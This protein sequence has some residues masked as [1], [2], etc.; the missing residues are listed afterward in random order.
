MDCQFWLDCILPMVY[1]NFVIISP[2][3]LFS[4]LDLK[5]SFFIMLER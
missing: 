3:L 4:Y 2:N 5:N 1:C